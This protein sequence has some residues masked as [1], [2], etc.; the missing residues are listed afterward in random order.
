MEK[1]PNILSALVSIAL[2]MK[3]KGSTNFHQ[4]VSKRDWKFPEARD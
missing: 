1:L 3:Y 2:Q 4:E